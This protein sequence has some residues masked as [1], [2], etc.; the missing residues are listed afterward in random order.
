MNLFSL[1]RLKRRL[2]TPRSPMRR[3]VDRLAR[4]DRRRE[5]EEAA[6]AEEREGDRR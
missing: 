6:V 5:A 4:A 3:S 1:V 2:L